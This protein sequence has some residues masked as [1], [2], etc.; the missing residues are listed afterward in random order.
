VLRGGQSSRSL[1][2]FCRQ[3]A[4]SEGEPGT[5]QIYMLQLY[6]V[7]NVFLHPCQEVYGIDRL[8]RK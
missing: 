5:L 4:S 7:F 3:G 6:E 2:D 1:S 8:L